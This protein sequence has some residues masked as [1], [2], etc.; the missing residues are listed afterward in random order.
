ML[1]PSVKS[2]LATEL[3]ARYLF[4]VPSRDLCL[5]WNI[6]SPAELS[7]KHAREAKEDYG[8]EEYNLSP[9]VYVYTDHWPCQKWK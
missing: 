3:G 9:H 7:E 8:S 4:T 6:S 1:L 2:K 5:F